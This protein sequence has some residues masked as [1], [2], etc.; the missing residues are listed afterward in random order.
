MGH[1]E[2]GRRMSA[3]S[4]EQLVVSNLQ[5]SRDRSV[6]RGI[7]CV[8][9]VLLTTCITSCVSTAAPSNES[10]PPT[11]EARKRRFDAGIVNVGTSA[12]PMADAGMVGTV[13]G[14]ASGYT[15]VFYLWRQAFV[16]GHAGYAST[17]AIVLLVY[18][19]WFYRKMKRL[20]II[21]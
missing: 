7:S 3:Q 12:A 20:R 5:Q 15:L 1:A 4:A 13:G 6:Q 2:P 10:T 9:Q 17:I 16:L 21:T 14:D 8:V 11:I 18:G 19:V